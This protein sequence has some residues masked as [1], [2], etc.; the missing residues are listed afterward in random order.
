[1]SW[2]IAAHTRQ[3]PS[4]Q[5]MSPSLLK[6]VELQMH[7]SIGEASTRP[8]FLHRSAH[9]HHSR[10]SRSGTRAAPNNPIA[11]STTQAGRAAAETPAIALPDPGLA[12]SMRRVA[13]PVNRKEQQSCSTPEP[14]HLRSLV[15]WADKVMGRPPTAPAAAVAAVAE[16]AAVSYA[17]AATPVAMDAAVMRGDD[18]ACVPGCGASHMVECETTG[19]PLPS[20]NQETSEEQQ[21][22]PA[23]C[24]DPRQPTG[25]QRPDMTTGNVVDIVCRGLG[26]V[27]AKHCV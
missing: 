22:C 17:R 15:S 27:I 21:V 10:T 19:N 18:T 4:T 16:P 12:A 3:Q 24:L 2:R 26:E 5:F 23:R 6:S 11:V 1:M 13:A 20:S 7:C 8:M 9:T 25:R 14:A